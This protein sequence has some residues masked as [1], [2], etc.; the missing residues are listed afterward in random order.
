[1]KAHNY[2]LWYSGCSYRPFTSYW[3]KEIVAQPIRWFYD[4]QAFYNR[5]RRGYD[6]G[7]IWD[8]MSYHTGVTLGLLRHF[9]KNYTGVPCAYTPEQYEAEIDL[10]IDAWEA[11]QAIQND[12]GFEGDISYEDWRKPLDERWE[13]GIAAFNRIYDSLWQ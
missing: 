4:L 10:A 11:K 6:N 3:W 8:L 2:V 9:R 13:K 12:E 5:G 1:M 7:D